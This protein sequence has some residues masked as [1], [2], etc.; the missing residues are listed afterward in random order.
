[1][2]QD[3]Q[4]L[5]LEEKQDIIRRVALQYLAEAYK[6]RAEARK[7]TTEQLVE[8]LWECWSDLSQWPNPF[9]A[10]SKFLQQARLVLAEIRPKR[11]RRRPKV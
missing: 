10:K 5:R 4:R 8:D 7:R 11:P 6:D 2:G 1:M 3:L 9:P